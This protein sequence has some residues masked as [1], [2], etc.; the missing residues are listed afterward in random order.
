MTN[1]EALAM[2]LG[3][4][5]LGEGFDPESGNEGIIVR[6]LGT[7]NHKVIGSNEE[8]AEEHLLSLKEYRETGC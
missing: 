6:E 4:E 8:Q 7:T 3:F 5:Y 1:L 2:E